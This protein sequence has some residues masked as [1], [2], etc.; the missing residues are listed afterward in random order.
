MEGVTLLKS[1]LY[2]SMKI[3][4]CNSLILFINDKKF[5]NF[6]KHLL[7]ALLLQA[8]SYCITNSRGAIIDLR[9]QYYRTEMF[10]FS[11]YLID[12]IVQEYT[13]GYHDY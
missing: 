2:A 7:L 3:S 13:N 6:R 8:V 10:S 12:N 4:Q 11:C 1:T 9:V 5:L